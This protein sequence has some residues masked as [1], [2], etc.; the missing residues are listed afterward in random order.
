MF[1]PHELSIVLQFLGEYK[2]PKHNLI[3]LSAGFLSSH[4]RNHRTSIV[5]KCCCSNPMGVILYWWSLSQLKRVKILNEEKDS[6]C[7]KCTQKGEPNFL[8]LLPHSALH[9][10][11]PGPLLSGSCFR[12]L[13][14]LRTQKLLAIWSWPLYP[15]WDGTQYIVNCCQKWSWPFCIQCWTGKLSLLYWFCSTPNYVSLLYP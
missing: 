1:N 8:G 3:I 5:G 4:S 6:F 11:W 13:R 2:V 10:D 12:R 15:L 7:T 9:S 14:S